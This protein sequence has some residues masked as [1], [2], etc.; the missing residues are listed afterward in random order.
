MWEDG[1]FAEAALKRIKG[2]IFRGERRGRRGINFLVNLKCAMLLYAAFLGKG[3]KRRHCGLESK[4]LF[5][6]EG[7]ASNFSFAE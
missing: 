7:V 2:F 3:K 5:W 1:S 4:R 6:K